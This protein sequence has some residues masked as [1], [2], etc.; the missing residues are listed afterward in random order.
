MIFRYFAPKLE[1]HEPDHVLPSFLYPHDPKPLLPPR[2]PFQREAERAGSDRLSR[3]RPD[4]GE[5]MAG[6]EE[7]VRG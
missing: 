6:R 7:G 4:S 3:R 5:R 1:Q 2:P